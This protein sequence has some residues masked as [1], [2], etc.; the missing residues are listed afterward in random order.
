MA[1]LL[2][3]CLTVAVLPIDWPGPPFGYGVRGSAAST[4]AVTAAMLFLAKGF[5]TLTVRRLARDP[6]D[7]EAAGRR[8]NQHRQLFFYLNLAALAFVL[9]KCGWGWTVREVLTVNDNLLPGAEL[10]TLAP[11]LVALVGSWTFFYD[12]ERALCQLHP[13]PA[14]R[15][16]FWSRGGYVLYTFRHHLL[17]VFLPVLLVIAQLGILR[18]YPQLLETLWAKLAAFAALFV[19]ILFIPSLVP[20]VLGLKRMEPGP[21]KDRLEAAARRLGV[22]YR[23]LYVWDTRGNLATAMVTGLVPYF[24]QIVFTDLLLQTLSEDEIEAVFGHEVGHVRHGHLLYYAAFLL[25]S[26]VSLGAAY[27]AFELSAG[28]PLLATDLLLV[29]SVVATGV[30]L[31]VVFGFLSRRCERQADV[32]GCKAVSCADPAC[33]AHRAGTPFVPRG[34][35]LCRTGVGTFVRAL[36]RVEAVNGIARDSVSAGRRGVFGRAAGLLRFVGVWLATWQHSTIAKRV[37]FLKTLADDPRRERRFQRRVALLRWGMLALLATSVV[38]VA[39]WQGWRA[40]L[41]GV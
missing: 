34:R 11:Y 13:N 15:A 41:D 5:S 8:H 33:D 4:G 36:E 3:I 20:L 19:F 6:G 22:K 9:L 21:L 35:G 25:L 38:A 37:E 29:L 17:T 28:G 31:F 1:L 7:H 12:A 23:H 26:F 30:Y 18:A 14:L 10:L 2:L 24:R 32:F 27:R 16:G 39:G 40:L